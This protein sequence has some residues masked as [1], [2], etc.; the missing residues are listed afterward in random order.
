MRLQQNFCPTVSCD[1]SLQLLGPFGIGS[2]GC[3]AHDG[4]QPVQNIYLQNC[5]DYEN[6]NPWVSGTPVCPLDL[7]K[8]EYAWYDEASQDKFNS[9]NPKDSALYNRMT[10]VNCMPNTFY[11]SS[12]N[13]GRSCTAN[14]QCVSKNCNNGICQ[15]L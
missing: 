13:N 7:D 1:V 4:K 10:E 5:E 15:G 11:G 8:Q 6:D 2:Y 12:L 9:A 14:E 3:Y